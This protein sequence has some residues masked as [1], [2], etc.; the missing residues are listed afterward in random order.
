MATDVSPGG[1][2]P[3]LNPQQREALR[4]RGVSVALS[5]GAGCGKTLVLT[6]RFLDE[7]RPDAPGG[8]AD[9][10]SLVA[11]TFTERA[12][13]EMRNRIRRASRR[14]LLECDAAEAAHWRGLIRELDAARISTIHSFCNALLRGLAVEAGLDPQFCV[15]DD[16]ESQTLLARAARDVIHSRLAARDEQIIR[17]A[18]LV[19]IDGVERR[20]ADFVALRAWID[21]AAWRDVTAEE[22]VGR[23][24][25]ACQRRIPELIVEQLLESPEAQAVESIARAAPSSNP[26]MRE[27]FASLVGILD[28]LRAGGAPPSGDAMLATL[29]AINQAARVQGGGSAKHWDDT[30]SY[31]RFKEQATSLR[32]KIDRKWRPLLEFDRGAALPAA[33]AGLDLLRLAEQAIERFDAQKRQLGVLDFN[34]LLI[35]A[36][37]L[38][39]GPERAELRRQ[40]ASRIRLLLVDE[41]QDTDPLQVELVRALCGDDLERGKLFFVGDYKQSIYRFRGADPRVFRRLSGE[42]PQPGRLPLSINYRSQPAILG[43]V[44]ALFADAMGPDYE[45]LQPSRPQIGPAPAVELLLAPSTETSAKSTGVAARREVEADWIARRI[46]EIIDSREPIVWDETA[47]AAGAP[48]PRA[49]RLGDVA[50]LFR[51]LTNVE[52]YEEALRRAG[53]DYYLVG[54]GAFYAQQEIRDLLHLLRAVDNPADE[55]ALVGVLRSTMFGLFDETLYA[56]ARRGGCVSAGLFAAEADEPANAPTRFGDLPPIG[57]AQRARV[58]FARETLRALRAMKDRVGVAELIHAALERTGYDAALLAEFL[59]RRKLANLHKLIDQARTLDRSGIFTLADFIFQLGQFIAEQPREPLAA[60]HPEATDVVRLMTIHQAKGLEFPIVVVPDIDWEPKG[61][62][63]SVAFSEDLGPLVVLPDNDGGAMR[64]HRL[65]EGREDEAERVRLLYVATTRAADYLILSACPKSPE[66][67]AGPWLR[68]LD[69]RFDLST[70]LPRAGASGSDA[71][72]SDAASGR[73]MIRVGHAPPATMADASGARARGL[74]WVLKQVTRNSAGRHAAPPAAILPIAPDASARREWSF[75]RLSGLLASA[76]ARARPG[77]PSPALDDQPELDPR[78]LGTLIHAVLAEVDFAQPARAVE[79]VRRHAPRHQ[80]A[81]Q[82]DPAAL[83]DEAADMVERFLASPRA[84]EL[85]RAAHVHRELEFILTFPPDLG[86]EEPRCVRGFI[87]CLYQDAAG[88]WRV[89]DFKTNRADDA[90]LAAVAEG[91]RM[92]MLVYG[93]AVKRILGQP[94]GELVLCFLRPGR[95]YLFAWNDDAESEAIEMVQRAMRAAEA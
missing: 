2:R 76:P 77:G 54:G 95:E 90:T 84:A 14:E 30:A 63:G 45:P 22:L 49:A 74:D 67:P 35:V 91:Y 36:G 66:Q 9:L 81:M 64:L 34:D 87:D 44:N 89:L 29:A 59:G 65:I 5:A 15:L 6:H 33:E 48:A 85:R 19:G 12:A 28:A 60:T 20:L 25:T 26:V 10:G 88:R 70:G 47:A 21:W 18:V 92:Q 23:W 31:E 56:L 17:L 57:E 32:D 83:I 16:A 39:L 72:P 53:L 8:A 37:R 93:L 51:A 41:F 58:A 46:R 24:E 79:L 50:L 40:L 94:P 7:L 80:G 52:V 62:R 61:S 11:I 75:S 71:A 68:L 69:T 82:A 4:K 86:R 3:G 43:F 1:P 38:L 13:R 73:P 42:I 78:G 55:V 27:R